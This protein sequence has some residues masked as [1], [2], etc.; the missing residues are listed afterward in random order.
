VIG[1]SGDRVPIL[2]QLLPFALLGLGIAI[3]LGS[4]LGRRSP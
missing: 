1:L 4:L 2:Q 3:V